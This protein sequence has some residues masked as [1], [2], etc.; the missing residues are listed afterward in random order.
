[1]SYVFQQ[2]RRDL[3]VRFINLHITCRVIRVL[4]LRSLGRSNYNYRT[5]LN[6][7][8]FY[9][10]MLFVGF[11]CQVPFRN[12][13]VFPTSTFSFSEVLNLPSGHRLKDLW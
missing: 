5:K 3:R 11:L 1:M 13:R 12:L 4:I 7:I 6:D 2:A 10:F 8:I 9:C